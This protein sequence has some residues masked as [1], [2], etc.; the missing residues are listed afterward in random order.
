V[1]ISVGLK[2]L[3][4]WISLEAKQCRTCDSTV[5]H[6]SQSSI[7]WGSVAKE[8]QLAHSDA[9]RLVFKNVL[10]TLNFLLTRNYNEAEENNENKSSTAVCKIVT[11]TTAKKTWKGYS[12]HYKP[13]SNWSREK[14][15]Y[16]WKC[17]ANTRH[18]RACTLDKKERDHSTS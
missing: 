14:P 16:W 8:T 1:T 18:N 2:N 17:F 9:T 5:N 12:K 11:K 7:K 6:H 13:Q 15:L 3:P 4:F 10:L